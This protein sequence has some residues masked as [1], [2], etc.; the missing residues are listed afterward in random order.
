MKIFTLLFI[1]LVLSLNALCKQYN[2]NAIYLNGFIEN[3]GQIID[4]NG[5][6]NT[7]VLFI[8]SSANLNLQLKKNSFSYE[9]KSSRKY[10]NV[11]S[12]LKSTA[13]IKHR[14]QESMD[15]V[16]LSTHRIDIELIGANVNPE[17]IAEDKSS[18]YLNYYTSETT[19]E[20]VTYVYQY[21]RIIYRNIYPNIDLEF[22]MNSSQDGS[23]FKYN[24]VVRPNGRLTD[25]KLKYIGGFDTKLN[26]NQI[27]IRTAFGEIAEAI[28]SSYILE[29]GKVLPVSYK[30]INENTYGFSTK[31]YP[32]NQTLLIDPWCTYF[33]G[34]GDDWSSSITTD[35]FDNIIAVGATSSL[36]NIATSGAHQTVLLGGASFG[37][38][39][40]AKFNSIGQL[41]WATYYGGNSYDACYCASSDTSGNII[42]AGTTGSSNNIATPGS[43]QDTSS[44]GGNFFAKFTA[45][46]VRLWGTYYKVAFIRTICTDI[47]GDI[48][49]VGDAATLTGL[50]TTSAYQ[51]VNGGN[52]DGF[53]SKFSAGGNLLWCTYFGGS[54]VDEC[55][56]VATDISNNILVTGYTFS[57]TNIATAGAHQTVKG[58][59]D[60]GF[61][62]KFTGSGAILWA[63]YYGG[64]DGDQG[65]YITSDLDKNLIMTGETSSSN[66]ITTAGA[67]KTTLS[68]DGQDAFVVKF[69]SNGNRLWGTYYGGDGA[70]GDHPQGITTDNNG[71][72]ILAGGT[73]SANGIATVGSY[74]PIYGGNYDGFMVKFYSAGGRLWGSYFG[75]TQ[76]D[77]IRGVALS[78]NGSIAVAGGT[79][80]TANIATIGS[81]QPVFGGGGNIG[82]A[83]IASFDSTGHIPPVGIQNF[84]ENIPSLIKVYPNPAKHKITV[85][86]NDN[87]C[88]GGSLVLMDI[89]G[90]AV[91][92]VIT[93][94]QAQG[95]K[96]IVI[97]VKDL[98]AGVYLLQYDDGE[99]CE[100]VKF[101][102]E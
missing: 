21:R 38:G 31:D 44:S 2:L 65:F 83:F 73:T 8:G 86:I 28:P 84:N 49:L 60:D 70:D 80:S 53:I 25:I 46:G 94:R 32:L 81:Y 74:Q 90:K 98:S 77:E 93:L 35:K 88:K 79:R 12:V 76:D 37:D 26:N 69:D 78:P 52:N 56:G 16:V 96:D 87:A 63:T 72:I 61:V 50:A 1:S 99:V 67:Y 20:G 14:K 29:T 101:V 62:A 11:N 22:K 17:I 45:V 9:V 24:F 68:L 54:D 39:F 55:W 41:L 42:I 33:G 92:S 48:L 7:S 71:N 57:A 75:G 30:Q 95:D 102:K 51:Q 3:K 82:D 85:S 100:T 10:Q 6:P 89:E 27:L 5:K 59:A 34:A 40:I 66:N 19:E 18:N 36:T 64:N 15:S 97:D 47:S 91:K 4:Q 43:Y 23:P 58:I 13:L